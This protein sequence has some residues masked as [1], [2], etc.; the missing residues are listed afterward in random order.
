ML[1]EL[2]ASIAYTNALQHETRSA[3]ARDGYVPTRLKLALSFGWRRLANPIAA[4][5]LCAR[6]NPK[7]LLSPFW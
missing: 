7:D 2:A 1:S 3:R 5:A 4:S 6:N